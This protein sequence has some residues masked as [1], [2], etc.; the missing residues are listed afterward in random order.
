SITDHMDVSE[1]DLDFALEFDQVRPAQYEVYSL[2]DPKITQSLTASS[3]ARISQSEEF[4]K[5][6]RRIDR[7]KEQKAKKRVTLNE[8]EF[9][10]ER[11]ELDAEKEDEKQ[12]EDQ[13]VAS[14]EVVK[15]DFYMNEVLAIAADYAT[16]LEQN[17][18]AWSR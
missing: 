3:E 12:L 1:A 8:Q 11:A 7:Y 17:R 6:L 10:A 9:F 5:L 2:A 18:I 16:L 13:A 4:K 14:D 15:R